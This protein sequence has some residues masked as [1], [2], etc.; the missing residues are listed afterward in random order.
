MPMPDSAFRKY[1]VLAGICIYSN[2]VKEIHAAILSELKSDDINVVGECIRGLGHLAWR[3]KK[4]DKTL[5]LSVHMRAVELKDSQYIS[6]I[7]EEVTG[8][9]GDIATFVP[10]LKVPAL[11]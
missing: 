2:D 7:W 10:L 4:V 8:P 11:Y 1:L 9:G 5:L 6:V 3:F